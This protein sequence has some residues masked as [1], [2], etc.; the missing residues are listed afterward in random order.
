[1]VVSANERHHLGDK[2]E[3]ESAGKTVAECLPCTFIMPVLPHTFDHAEILASR[4][5]ELIS[6]T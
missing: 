5:A 6:K 4:F 2:D 3:R 1:M